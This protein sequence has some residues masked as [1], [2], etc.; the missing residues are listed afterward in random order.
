[1]AG[2]VL[3]IAYLAGLRPMLVST[4]TLRRVVPEKRE[5]LSEIQNLVGEYERISEEI[6]K[7]GSEVPEPEAGFSPLAFI[8]EALERSGL[9]P[10]SLDP[11]EVRGERIT[12]V[13]IDV[14]INDAGWTEL[15]DF[16]RKLDAAETSL[17][18]SNFDIRHQRR[19]DQL[20][21]D[22][23]VTGLRRTD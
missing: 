16:F 20:Q 1:M 13:T 23:T 21:A 6:E 11:S 19:G 8:E 15:I 2:I 7:L 3:I 4:E 5:E 10:E 17:R 9:T 12:Q 18:L 22:I 14:E